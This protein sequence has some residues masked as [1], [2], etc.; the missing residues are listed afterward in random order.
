M[1][2]YTTYI[3]PSGGL[4][5]TYHLLGEPETTNEGCFDSPNSAPLR[6]VIET[7]F[8]LLVQEQVGQALTA[9]R[10]GHVAVKFGGSRNALS[11]VWAKKSL[12]RLVGIGWNK[13]EWNNDVPFISD[14]IGTMYGI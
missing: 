10:E 14:P 12:H 5:A 11:Y 3:L 2:V 7:F 4:Y 13:K 1:A 9:R 8:H 6:K